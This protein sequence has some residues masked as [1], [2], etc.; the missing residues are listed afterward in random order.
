MQI[1]KHY[2]LTDTIHFQ[3]FPRSGFD[4]FPENLKVI[5]QDIA[6]MEKAY[7]YIISQT[8]EGSLLSIVVFCKEYFPYEKSISFHSIII[9]KAKKYTATIALLTS[10]LLISKITKIPSLISRHGPEHL[11]TLLMLLNLGFEVRELSSISRPHILVEKILNKNLGKEIEISCKTDIKKMCRIAY[12]LNI[13][14]KD[15]ISE[16]LSQYISE[17]VISSSDLKIL[18]RWHGCPG[19][20]LPIP[21]DKLDELYIKQPNIRSHKIVSGNNFIYILQNIELESGLI[22]FS[23]KLQARHQFLSLF[24]ILKDRN[25]LETIHTRNYNDY[26]NSIFF[27]SGYKF[28]TSIK[29]KQDNYLYKW[30]RTI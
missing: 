3:I 9:S 25:N 26:I 17:P 30:E 2:I 21:L 22:L 10:Y 29:L 19:I 4:T 18:S 28:V 14:N 23:S 27:L 20:K 8:R 1:N 24:Y 16:N 6:D 12:N 7:G 11:D 15:N 5:I 13:G